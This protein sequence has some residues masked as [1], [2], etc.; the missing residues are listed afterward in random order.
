MEAVTSGSTALIGRSKQLGVIDDVLAVLSDVGAGGVLEVAGEPGI[1]KTRLLDE[2]RAD[3]RRRDYLVLAGRAAEFEG[4]LPFGVFVD[5]LDDYL[6]RLGEERLADLAGRAAPLL[7][8]AL[9]AFEP[10]AAGSPPVLTEERFRTHRALRSL[11][12]RLAEP[13]PVVLI[14]DDLHWADSGSIEMLNHLLA[15]PPVGAVLLVVAFRPAQLAR[16]LASSLAERLR[17]DGARRLDLAPLAPVEALQL[18]GSAVAGPMR[19]QLVAQSGGN[20]LFLQEL[21][22][23]AARPTKTRTRPRGLTPEV[24]DAVLRVLDSEIASLSVSAQ[25]LLQGAAAAGDPFEDDLAAVAADLGLDEALAGFDELFQAGLITP[26]A[27]ARRFSFRHPLVRAA[28]YQSAGR[29]WMVRAHGRVADAMAKRGEPASARAHHIERS[30]SVGDE[31]AVA[32]LTEAGNIVGSRAPATAAEWFRAAGTLL[33]ANAESVPQ[34]ISLLI[35]LATAL[36]NSGSLEESAAALGEVLQLLPPE[37]PARAAVVA[38]SAGIEHLLGHHSQARTRLLDTYNGLADRNSPEGVAL[39]TQL[40]AACLYQSLLEEGYA[41]AERALTASRPLDD[42][43]LEATAAAAVLLTGH[44]LGL[45]ASPILSTTTDMVA[46]LDDNLLATRLDLL[47]ALCWGQF[48]YE[49]FDDC[50]ALAERATR[51]SRATGQG[52]FLAGTMTAQAYALMLTGRLPEAKTVLD[53]VIE[54]Y[55]LSPNA[56]LATATGVASIVAC[57]SGD[58]D[59]ALALGEESV[60]QARLQQ[61][62]SLTAMAG[63][64]FSAALVETGH[65]ERAKAVA[66][67]MCGGPGLTMM[68]S[69]KVVVYEA[70]TRADLALGRLEAAE[71]WA[72]NA[73]AVTDGGELPVECAIA[74]RAQ[75]LVLASAG[76]HGPAGQLALRAAERAESAGAP[77]E[78]ARCRIVAGRSLAQAGERDQAISLLEQAEDRMTRCGAFCFRDQAERELRRLGRRVTRR[79]G[80]VRPEEGMRA[81]TERERE[82]AHLV[83][84]GQ[85]NRQIAAAAYLSEKTVERHLSHIFAKLGISTRSALAAVVAADPGPV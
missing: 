32:A 84:R 82:L 35:A 26:T 75:A 36:G 37:E 68:T 13:H 80:P 60:T 79:S 8:V 27:T 10:L 14:L 70:L 63:H 40:A 56:F 54:A 57:W 52:A 45:P 42:P 83:A 50:L 4:E 2:L 78:A 62:G 51:V 61:P 25:A 22:R 81:L 17:R 34:R 30:A 41:W 44:S 49:R 9:P 24:P 48:Q 33:P 53:E 47:L 7:A 59:A 20:P 6:G 11:L 55:R 64:A 67:E 1:G 74:A 46:T 73:A 3:A 16:P 71:R 31:Q 5:A 69:G 85:T 29:A 38:Y 77:V 23:G 18:L 72:A 15:Y 39:A 58:N 76:N 12:S 19:E 28:V 65:F 66:F 21:A 43:L